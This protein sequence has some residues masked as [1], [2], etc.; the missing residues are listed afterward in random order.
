MHRDAEPA[1]RAA[2]LAL[3]VVVL[4]VDPGDAGDREDRLPLVEAGVLEP[5][6]GRLQLA[7]PRHADVRARPDLG[8]TGTPRVDA[9]GVGDE[10][11]RPAGKASSDARNHCGRLPAGIAKSKSCMVSPRRVVGLRADLGAGERAGEQRDEPLV[12]LDHD[13]VGCVDEIGVTGGE[14]QLV[15]DALLAVA[16]DAPGA[17]SGVQRGTSSRRSSP[18]GPA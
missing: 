15:A 13:V 7:A 10:E 8:E 4:E 9:R 3:A 6:L 16:A 18:R 2:E 12:A 17:V 11:R 1:F 5:A 14:Q